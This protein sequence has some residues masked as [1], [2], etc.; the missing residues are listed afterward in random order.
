[1][2]LKKRSI[3]W[4]GSL[5]SASATYS[6]SR[7]SPQRVEMNLGFVMFSEKRSPAKGLILR[8][9]ILISSLMMVGFGLFSRISF[10]NLAARLIASTCPCKM[11]ATDPLDLFFSFVVEFVPMSLIKTIQSDLTIA[12]KA[13]DSV[14]RDTIRFIVSQLKYKE[15]ETKRESTDDEVIS[16]IRKQ[17]KELQESSSQFEK[18]GRADL[19]SENSAQIKVLEKYLPSEISDAELEKEI[20]TFVEA[21]L[22]AYKANPKALTGKIVQ[23]LKVKASPSRIAATY[24]KM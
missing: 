13:H 21:N 17:I 6:S 18:G 2:S 5:L 14:T 16:A 19:A 22:E 23:A 20:K 8:A 15:I 9:F 12:L 10:L 24:G 1:M 7:K 3:S 4:F 11:G